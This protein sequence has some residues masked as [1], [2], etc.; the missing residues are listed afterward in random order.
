MPAPPHPSCAIC[1]VRVSPVEGRG[2]YL[3]T[4]CASYPVLV[5]AFREG[6]ERKAAAVVATP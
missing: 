1:E 4:A 6:L 5:A 3:C 2:V